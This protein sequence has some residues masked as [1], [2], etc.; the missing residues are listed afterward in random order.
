[1]AN[2]RNSGTSVTLSRIFANFPV[3]RRLIDN[4]KE[5]VALQKF[6]EHMSVFHSRVYFR[7]VSEE[8]EIVFEVGGCC[9]DIKACNL[10]FASIN[11]Q[12]LNWK[13]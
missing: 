13:L 6:L 12:K 7:L 4:Q 11:L 3:R 1:M 9:T 5:K 10:S 8:E 2:P